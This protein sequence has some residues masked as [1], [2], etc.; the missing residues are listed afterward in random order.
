MMCDKWAKEWNGF[1]AGV[2]TSPG[3]E[4]LDDLHIKNGHGGWQFYD[5]HRYDGSRQIEGNIQAVE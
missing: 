4:I 5:T 2:A 3:N 1:T